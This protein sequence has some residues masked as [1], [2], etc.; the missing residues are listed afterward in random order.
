MKKSNLLDLYTDFLMTSPNVASA[1]VMSKMLQDAYSHDSIT[2]MLAQDELDQSAFWK[3]IKPTIRQVESLEGIISIDDTIEHKPYSEENE[4]ISWHFDHTQGKSVKG[5]NIVT[6]NYS[7]QYDD[8][9][10]KIP[11]SFELV[12]KDK[13]VEKTEKKDG[14]FV[15]RM[16]R[17]A[18]IGKLELVK[19]RLQVLV[20]QNQIKF[21]YATFDTWYSDADLISYIAKDPQRR[22]L[23]KHAVFARL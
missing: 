13:L 5:I 6:F 3:L 20:F 16:V 17:Q 22:P 14:K 23:K 15:T 10:M 19:R 9:T 4:L 1:L 11:V 2:R 18:S 21:K 12:R 8:L 7:S